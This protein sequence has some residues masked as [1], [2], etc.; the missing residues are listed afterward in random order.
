VTD[1]NVILSTEL[2]NMKKKVAKLERERKSRIEFTKRREAALVV[3]DHLEHE[4]DRDE[5]KL[6]NN[7]MKMLPRWKGIPVSKIRAF[8]KSIVEEQP[9]RRRRFQQPHPVD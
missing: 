9:R 8:Y 5:D 6:C 1:E 7:K 4:L 2:K 3:L